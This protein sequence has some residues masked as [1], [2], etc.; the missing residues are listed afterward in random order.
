MTKE[1]FRQ[2]CL[3]TSQ[4]PRI[5]ILDGGVSTHLQDLLQGKPFAHRELWSSSLLLDPECHSLIRQG[6]Q[7][8]LKSGANVLTTVT[9]QCHYETNLWPAII[10][11]STQIDHLYELALR[12]AKTVAQE[13]AYLFVSSG[14]YGGALSNGAE[15][16]G[17]YGNATKEELVRFHEMK[18]KSI[19]ALHPDGVAIETVP[20]LRECDALASLLSTFPPMDCWVSLSCRNDSEI[21]DGTSLRD[22]MRILRAI[23]NDRLTAIG[24]NCCHADHLPGLVRIVT[25]ELAK[26]PRRGIVLYPNSGEKWDAKKVSWKTDTGYRDKD[27]FAL[28]IME[29]IKCI[30]E[31]WSALLPKEPLP[32]ILVGGCCRTTPSAIAELRS[33][34]QNHLITHSSTVEQSR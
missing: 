29:A 11:N 17:D 10:T 27:A 2:W 6:H 15:Y 21:N 14:C 4:L 12:L 1:S 8:W 13:N 19:L 32:A 5:L 3:D 28:K 18:L 25:T 20:S 26:G 34:V 22:A 16:T 31:T 7:D 30:E 24:I 9:Y 23:P 33:R